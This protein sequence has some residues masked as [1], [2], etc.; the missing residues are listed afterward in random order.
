[1]WENLNCLRTEK[2]ISYG[3]FPAA[4]TYQYCRDGLGDGG[5]P[6]MP[7]DRRALAIASGNRG[8]R[9]I[10]RNDVV[11]HEYP[12]SG[13]EFGRPFGGVFGWFGLWHW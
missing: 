10:E 9:R 7:S 8:L 1:L 2:E 5:R 11:L 3:G 4:T 12:F 6:I 13:C